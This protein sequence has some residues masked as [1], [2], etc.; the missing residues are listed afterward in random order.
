MR[1][2]IS[3]FASIIGIV[4]LFCFYAA[5]FLGCPGELD[6]GVIESMK[7]KYTCITPK[8]ECNKKNKPLSIGFL[9]SPSSPGS[10]TDCYK[11][12][13]GGMKDI[14]EDGLGPDDS[15][16]CGE[17]NWVIYDISLDDIKGAHWLGLPPSDNVKSDDT[18]LQFK[19]L[20][21]TDGLYIA[22]DSEAVHKPDWLEGP[23]AAFIPSRKTPTEL[24]HIIITKTT[25]NNDQVILDL[26][27]LAVLPKEDQEI[28]LPGN[29]SGNVSW[30]TKMK[31]E[32]SA[33]YMVIIKPQEEDDCSQP[34]EREPSVYTDNHLSL[35]DAEKAAKEKCE[36]EVLKPGKNKEQCGEPKC[37]PVP[38]ADSEAV[39]RILS[40]LTVEPVSFEVSSEIEFNPALYPSEA[41]VSIAGHNYT[42]NVTGTLYFEYVLDNF[43]HLMTMK[44]NSMVLK[45]DPID[46]SI[47]NFTD[48]KVV[49]LAPVPADCKDS[50]P[51]YARPCTL[52][53]IANKQDPSDPN[54]NKIF[55]TSISAKKGDDTFLY[56]GKNANVLDITIDHTKAQ[57]YHR[58]RPADDPGK[59]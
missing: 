48:I 36:E 7:E 11:D 46:T 24:H 51:L 39:S 45:I 13:F 40:G 17:A 22:Y 47:G 4:L 25:A 52:Y 49:L 35:E 26:Y 18:Y 9:S 34:E 19:V 3:V 31:A 2:I 1:K 44:I 41:T 53:Q 58:R 30:P 33:M 37:D 57:F 42:R 43:K 5:T 27:K 14:N 20:K 16:Y 6:K 28:K 15:V 32:E 55:V 56:V 38:A 12:F 59:S 10:P 50:N 29:L 54:T 23:N 8:E 21:D